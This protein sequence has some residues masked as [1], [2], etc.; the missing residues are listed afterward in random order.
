MK[1]IIFDGKELGPIVNIFTGS[2]SHSDVAKRMAFDVMSA[3]TI[4]GG[5]DSHIYVKEH[6]SMT[7]KIEQNNEAI[8]RDEYII[9]S[10]FKFSL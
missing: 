5:Y 6:G 1:Y 4:G 9:Q 2:I 3:G 7:L 10:H 8:K